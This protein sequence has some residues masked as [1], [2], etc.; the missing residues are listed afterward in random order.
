MWKKCISMLS[1][2]SHALGI[3]NIYF[4]LIWRKILPINWRLTKP[5]TCILVTCYI[6]FSSITIFII[7]LLYSIFFLAFIVICFTICSGGT[8]YSKY[9]PTTMFRVR[10]F[11]A[12]YS[13]LYFYI[14][15]SSWLSFYTFYCLFYCFYIYCHIYAFI[16]G[17]LSDTFIPNLISHTSLIGSH[18][19][20]LD[21][22]SRL[23]V[24][25]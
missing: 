17:G 3:K 9:C 19:F 12:I 18:F 14:P 23:F 10:Q 22:I 1:V 8:D 6:D 7:V 13:Q 11:F 16:L 21:Q 20:Q 25:C 5:F 4:K 24:L 15:N 2:I